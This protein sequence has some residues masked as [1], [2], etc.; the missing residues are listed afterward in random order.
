M[1]SLREEKARNAFRSRLSY[2]KEIQYGFDL[3]LV[4]GFQ[5]NISRLIKDKFFDI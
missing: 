4:F 1:V 3:P 5:L 2:L